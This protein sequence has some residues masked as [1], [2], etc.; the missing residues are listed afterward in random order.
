MLF[1]N[2]EILMEHNTL[3]TLN[4]TVGYEKPII[5]NI[6]CSLQKG[7]FITLFGSNGAGKSTLIKTLTRKIT[8]INGEIKLEGKYLNNYASNELSKKIALVSTNNQFDLNLTVYDILALGRLPYLN[9]FGKLMEVD[10]NF[11]DKYISLLNIN[12]LRSKYFHQLSD[13]QKQKILIARALIQNTPIIILDEPTTHLDIKNRVLIFKLLKEI[14]QSENKSI[15]CATHEL[16]T[17]LDYCSKVWLIDKQ[18]NFID[19]LPNK[20]TLDK[21]YNLLF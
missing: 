12:E 14:A 8:P 4:L 21:A 2:N 11:I 13:G 18:N 9:L 3:N 5:T 6:N 16:N 19:T 15:I 1:L 20:L 17:A 10:I 7:D